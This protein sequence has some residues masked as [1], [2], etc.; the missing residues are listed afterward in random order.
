MRYGPTLGL[1]L[2][3]SAAFG[4]TIRVPEDYA[5]IQA[6]I[7]AAVAGDTVVV[8]PGNYTHW[9]ARIVPGIG[10]VTA[11]VFMKEAVVVESSAGP[12]S[13]V[14][15]LPQMGGSGI[16]FWAAD[17]QSAHVSG[18]TV[19]S[20]VLGNRGA[21][22]RYCESATVENCWF[23]GLE[24]LVAAGTGV[25]CFQTSLT[26]KDCLFEDCVG[27]AGAGL[28]HRDGDVTVT[29]TTFRSCGIRGAKLETEPPGQ[30]TVVVRECLF[31]ENSQGGLAADSRWVTVERCV[32]DGNYSLSGSVAMTVTGG[33]TVVRDCLVLRN[34]PSNGALIQ[35]TGFSSV[36]V[37]SNTIHGAQALT[38]TSGAAL[39]LA[40]DAVVRGNVI[41][42]TRGATAVFGGR[43]GGC[44]VFFDNE[45]GAGID[46]HETDVI[47]DPI[48]CDVEA[49]DLHVRSDSPCLPENSPEGCGLIGT[50]GQGCGTV[51]V[52]SETWGRVKA[53]F[54][55]ADGK[56]EGR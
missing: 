24:S 56:G 14:L 4:G 34:E 45:F 21:L 50:L 41:T 36:L 40:P 54:R 32:F 33:D 39:G 55:E 47:A 29:G 6:G 16:G 46:L 48:Y 3:V 37:E 13:T 11:A 30:A 43:S 31:E 25:R 44:N 19:Q 23:L 49:G 2:S 53:R 12:E 18:F 38:G 9:E 42:G 27:I 1:M 15:L 5:T 26:I 22:I 28:W 20:A 35:A 10:E 52:D 7:D 17:L 51:S 8:G